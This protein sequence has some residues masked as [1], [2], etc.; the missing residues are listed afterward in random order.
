[1]VGLPFHVQIPMLNKLVEVDVVVGLGNIHIPS[2]IRTKT[3]RVILTNLSI[4]IVVKVTNI[5]H[6]SAIYPE[7]IAA[8]EV[9]CRGDLEFRVQV[10]EVYVQH[11]IQ[12]VGPQH[13]PGAH[14]RGRRRESSP[15]HPCAV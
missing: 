11:D 12:C 7:T 15:S 13:Q 8:S 2:W 4:H 6:V 5:G 3:I 9:A 14:C 1:M 10:G